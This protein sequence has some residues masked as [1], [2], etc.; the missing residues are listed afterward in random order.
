MTDILSLYRPNPSVSLELNQAL[1]DEELAFEA[2]KK[3]IT[4]KRTQDLLFLHMGQILKVI[5]DR[6]LY[7]T[8]DYD[9]FSQFL[10]SDDIDMGRDKAYMYIH[11]YELY[12]ER[13]G[14]KTEDLAQ[15]GIG[16]LKLLSSTVKDLPIEE[17]RARVEDSRGV[18]YN[19]FVREIKE[20]NNPTG[21]PAVYFSEED[22]KWRVS[23]YEDITLLSN[24]GPFNGKKE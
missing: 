15:M 10:A 7:K 16:R 9:N 11:A 1:P 22:G 2:L 23:F 13:L 20:S 6:K 3:L 5:R 17:A 14:Y 24:L 19:E 18:R 12:V 4:A 8:L 21:R